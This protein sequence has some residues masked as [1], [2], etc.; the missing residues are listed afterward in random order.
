M[1]QS[2]RAAFDREFDD[3][4]DKLVHLS[5]MVDWAIQRAM[6]ALLEQDSLTAE[7]VVANDGDVNR[8]RFEIEEAC[9]VLIATRQPA[10]SDLRSVVAVMHIVVELE[11]MGDHAAGIA[12]IVLLM[13]DEPL[14]KT[15]KK[16]PKMGELSRQMLAD[17]VQS[18]LKRD[19]EWARE[20]A[21]RD[22]RLDKLYHATIDRLLK[23]MVKKPDA[24]QRCTYLMW[25]AHNLERIADRSTNIAEQVV[26][27]MTGDMNE[28]NV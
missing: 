13:E 11:R 27:M 12:R 10:A 2:L 3:I 7:A 20:I 5:Q 15:L 21:G 25:V 19:P 26:Y 14:L 9:I 23:F 1:P 6:T 22:A 4:C 17:V 18:F 28:L 16:F 8:L 24:V